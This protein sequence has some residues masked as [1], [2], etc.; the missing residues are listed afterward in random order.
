VVIS[1]LFHAIFFNLRDCSQ[2]PVSIKDVRREGVPLRS[3]R[4]LQMRT[5]ALFG[6]KN[7]DY[8]KFMACTHRQGGLSQ[9]EHFADKG[10]GLFFRGFVRTS[11]MDGPFPHIWILTSKITSF[12]NHFCGLRVNISFFSCSFRCKPYRKYVFEKNVILVK[13][14][15]LL[16]KWFPNYVGSVKTLTNH[17]FFKY[18]FTVTCWLLTS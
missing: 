17:Q 13:V 7:S 18:L 10:K 9:C 3:R 14:L 15:G 5:F 12:R 16:N 8:S 1:F 11:F 4:I 6:A 2:C